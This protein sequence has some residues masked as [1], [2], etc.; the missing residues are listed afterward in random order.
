M[1]QEALTPAAPAPPPATRDH[2][3]WVT[4]LRGPTARETETRGEAKALHHT[5]TAVARLDR[6]T[7]VR[8]VPERMFASLETLPPQPLPNP[9]QPTPFGPVMSLNALTDQ[10]LADD[11]EIRIRRA[12]TLERGYNVETARA[13]GRPTVS[14][15]ASSGPSLDLLA[16]ED[17]SLVNAKGKLGLTLDYNLLDFGRTRFEVL[18]AQRS[19]DSANAETE[20]E[21][22]EKVFEALDTLLRVGQI[23]ET[24]A[25]NDSHLVR[26]EELRVLIAANADEGNATAVDVKRVDSRIEATQSGLIGLRSQRA[27]AV[28]GFRRLTGLEADSIDFSALYGPAILSEGFD[29][30][31]ILSN[32]E[33]RASDAEI[34]S[35]S[36][37]EEAVRRGRLP[38]LSLQ[39]GLNYNSEDMFGDE[40]DKLDAEIS[41]SLT[42]D[43]YDGGA[44]ASRRGQLRAQR[45]EAELRRQRKLRKIE[46]EAENIA[47]FTQSQNRKTTLLQDRV[48]SLENVA[49]LYRE[50][51]GIGTRTVFEMLESEA[52]LLAARIELSAHINDRARSALQKLRLQGDLI[53][54]DWVG[55]SA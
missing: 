3:G 50:Q 19:L 34:A 26:L 43:L 16:G 14:L 2:S 29:P 55:D 54:F 1:I 33:I 20:H 38:N 24:T 48:R 21:A 4:Y 17:D 42:F 5:R 13:G 23:T 36:A 7:G 22:N 30:G 15:N 8:P 44:S 31:S 45:A 35:L 52:D 46:E 18:Q 10:V 32:P 41:L 40:E 39:S 28:S 27:N 25:A 53:E 49:S 11:L 6:M 37:Q 9:G 12:R 47:T 51:F